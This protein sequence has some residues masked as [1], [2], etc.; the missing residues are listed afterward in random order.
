[1]KT[2]KSS[3]ISILLS[4]FVL[5]FVSCVSKEEKALEAAIQ[6]RDL[7][8]LRQYLTTFPDADSL[9]LDSARAVLANWVS[10]STDFASLKQL[11]D[12]VERAEAEV[13][14]MN[15]FPEGLYIDSVAQMYQTDES[16]AVAIVARREAIAQYLDPYRKKFDKHVY[17]MDAYHYIILTAPDDEGK[18]QGTLVDG[19][20]TFYDFHYAFNLDD[21]DDED[22][23]CSYDK[24]EDAHFTL[25][26][27]DKTLYMQSKGELN[28]FDGEIDEKTYQDFLERVA[29]INQ[30][31]EVYGNPTV[32]LTPVDE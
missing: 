27:Y 3:V 28:S 21:F 4:A 15:N 30:G 11:E 18:G 5:T 16:E 6:S 20:L 19:I 31:Q 2:F 7:S 13:T 26:I 23:Q 25:S 17:Y 14:Y 29:K 8:Q 24:Y 10:D 12:V 32:F 1:M 22:I 9:L